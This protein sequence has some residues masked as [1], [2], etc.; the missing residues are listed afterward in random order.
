MTAPEW[1]TADPGA[2]LF[3]PADTQMLTS[4]A[5][6]AIRLPTSVHTELDDLH[7]GMRPGRHNLR[8]SVF[9]DMGAMERCGRFCLSRCVSAMR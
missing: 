1:Q 7:V 3:I 9:G 6:R 2:R 4:A 8:P 5:I